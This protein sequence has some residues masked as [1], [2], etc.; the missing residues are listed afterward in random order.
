[1]VVAQA[2]STGRVE[3]LGGFGCLCQE[4]EEPDRLR[5]LC[6]EH[7]NDDIRYSARCLIYG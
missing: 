3:R 2:E 4:Q 5:A 1:M 7:N 6:R